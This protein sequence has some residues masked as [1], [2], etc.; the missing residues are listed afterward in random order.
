MLAA[1]CSEVHLHFICEQV[2]VSSE[3]LYFLGFYFQIKF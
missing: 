3:T 1:V 2:A